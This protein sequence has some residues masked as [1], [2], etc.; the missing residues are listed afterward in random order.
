MLGFDQIESTLFIPMIGRIYVSERFPRI[1]FDEKALSLKEHLPVGLLEQDRQSQYALIASASRSANMDCCI[2]N[3]LTHYPQ[4]GIVQLGCGLET[5]FY[6]N[7]NGHTRWY[8]V[9]LPDV[10]AYRRSLLP[11]QER[12]VYLAQDAFSEDW[13]RLVRT[14]L[15]DAPLLVTA[16]G[17]FHYFSEE[18]VLALLRMLGQFGNL[19]MVFDAVN[20]R[21]I[22]MLRKN[23]MKRAGHGDAELLFYV[24]NVRDLAYKAGGGIRL[25][26]ETPY[27]Q[28]IPRQGLSFPTKLSMHISDCLGMVKMI[29]FQAG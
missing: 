10:I 24:D 18:K 27:Y 28:H 19:E 25:L 9:D 5:T 3:F 21:G 20:R 22:A 29:R 8:A 14:A 16:G 4:G 11:E 6:R 13:I 2:Q 23:Y 17:L 7:D 12:E 1:L 15:P 26:S